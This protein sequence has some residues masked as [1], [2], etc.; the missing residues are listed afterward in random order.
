MQQ[1]LLYYW[2]IKFE[3]Y[4]NGNDYTLFMVYIVFQS[5]E[6]IF[7]INFGILICDCNFFYYI[8]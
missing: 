5:E 4:Q 7:E 6:V 3:Q 2:L 1:N 8:P